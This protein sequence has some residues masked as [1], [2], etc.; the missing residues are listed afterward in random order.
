MEKPWFNL[1]P[2]DFA[3]RWWIKSDIIDKESS[4]IEKTDHDINCYFIIQDCNSV[5]H[6]FW[7]VSE[8][9]KN[10]RNRYCNNIYENQWNFNKKLE[11]MVPGEIVYL[12]DK[13]YIKFT[14]N[15][16]SFIK[17][18]YQLNFCKILERI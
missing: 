10:D 18:E 7:R 6:L 14:V 8:W 2:D 1:N 15:N 12:I 17:N 5:G 3:S 9:F 16:C 13:P 11:E 4:Q